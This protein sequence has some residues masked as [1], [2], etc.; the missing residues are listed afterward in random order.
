MTPCGPRRIWGSFADMW[1]A[2]VVEAEAERDAQAVA[3]ATTAYADCAHDVCALVASERI[4]PSNVL[5]P[6]VPRP[7]YGASDAA[8]EA[9]ARGTCRA[10]AAVDDG[11]VGGGVF[12]RQLV[13]PAA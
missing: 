6:M 8:L 5:L 10:A 7:R 2:A 9:H 3:D 4:A 12:E 13:A 11:C 1:E